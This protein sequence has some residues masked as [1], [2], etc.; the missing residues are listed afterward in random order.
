MVEGRKVR[1]EDR[2]IFIQNF[3]VTTFELRSGDGVVTFMILRLLAF[4]RHV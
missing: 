1:E 2:G 4:A 3:R